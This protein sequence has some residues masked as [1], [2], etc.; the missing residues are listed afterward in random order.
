[1][2]KRVV[3][4]ICGFAVVGML[5]TAA[6][7]QTLATYQLQTYQPGVNPATGTPFQVDPIP[8]SAFVC[9]QAPAGAPTGVVY[10]PRLVQIDDPVNAG[11]ACVFDAEAGWLL[12]GAVRVHGNTFSLTFEC[13]P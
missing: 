2:L 4:R 6:S 12:I 8:A 1:M 3:G 13:R 7:A 9:N 10:N 11:R 5:S